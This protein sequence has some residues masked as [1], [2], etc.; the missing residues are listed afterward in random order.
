MI[1]MV[2]RERGREGRRG[3]RKE[4]REEKRKRKRKQKENKG[5]TTRAEP[6]LYLSVLVLKKSQSNKSIRKLFSFLF[7]EVGTET[8][9]PTS[10]SP[11]PVSLSS[12]VVSTIIDSSPNEIT[13]EKPANKKTERKEE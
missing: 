10:L 5:F 13:E 9:F 11:D 3:G 1:S 12:Y 7:P 2:R 4:G 6:A 8:S